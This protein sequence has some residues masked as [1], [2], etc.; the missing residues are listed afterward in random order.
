MMRSSVWLVAA[1]ACVLATPAAG[2]AVSGTDP[3]FPR[4]R[5][6]GYIFGDVY[7]NVSGDPEHRYN[8]SGADS[9]RVNLDGTFD[10]SGQ[11]RVIGRDLNGVQI[12]RV[13]FQADNDLSIKYSTRFRLEADSRSLTSDGK[14]GVFV[15]AAYLQV[16][17]LVPRGNALFGIIDTP[18]WATSEEAWGYRSVEK[19]IADFRG[20]ASS[21]DL[22]VQ[23][24]GWL[25]G[26]HRV[27]YAA[28]LG[29]GTG[30]K[31]EDNRYKR[32]YV[33][34][35]LLP[36][37]DLKI[38]PYV[39]YEW[40]P[41]NA[42][43][44]TYKLYAGYQFKR[45]LVGGEIVDRVNHTTSGPNREPFGFSIFGRYKPADKVQAFARFDRWQPN[46]R[47]A[48]RVDAEL[49][50]AGLDWEPYKD[51]HVI[52]NVEAAQYHARGAA[53]G[54][55]HHDVQARVTMYFRFSKP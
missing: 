16:K 47:A 55:P 53:T 1:L 37:E 10:S 50:I 18:T 54:P 17:N 15:K 9:A 33:S 22:G 3:D 8:S 25:D 12:R 32:I 2:Q 49:W 34:A 6:S 4:G 11:P 36:M 27:G 52:P 23:L 35:P 41:G 20:L 13:Y 40:A 14:I 29:T 19:T 24:R 43:R 42:D 26:A 21:A 31:P 30:Q 44:A 48:N 45:A 39:D 5:I 7:Y 46:T 51:V 28:M 38:E